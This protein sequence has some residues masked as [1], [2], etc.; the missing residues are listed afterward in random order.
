VNNIDTAYPMKKITV[1]FTL[2]AFLGLGSGLQAAEQT[3]PDSA[4]SWISQKVAPVRLKI[5]LRTIK[6]PK[7]WR[8][9][10]AIKDIPRRR[11][12]PD[13][14]IPGPAVNPVANKVDRL[15]ST[16]NS[17][18][19]SGIT[20]NRALEL[21]FDGSGYTGVN[22]PDPTGDIGLN[23]YIQSINGSGGSIFTVYD[24][25][26][27]ALVSGPTAM[28]SL[29]SGACANGSGDPIVLFDEMADRWL[30][31]EFSGSGNNLCVYI[32]QTSDPVT[33]GWFAYTFVTPNF[34]DYPKYAVG[35]DAYYVGTNENSPAVYALDRDA[36]LAGD[37][38][39]MIRLTAPALN[40][41][42]FQMLTPAD[43]DG[44]AAVP[45]GTPGYFLRHRDDEVHN[46]SSNN[47]AE[48]YVELWQ[49]VAD[50]D[51]VNNASFTKVADF[52]VADFSS[53]L[54]GLF[55]FNCFPQA[56]TNTTL[57]PL[58]EVVMFSPQYRNFGTY[59]TIV[60]NFVTDVDGT[61][62]GGIRWFEL[63]RENNSWS[64]FQEGTYAPD[65]KNRWMGS[66][67]M[68]KDGNIALGYS[69]GSNQ[70]FPGIRYTG[71]V[72]GGASGS[73][74]EPEVTLVNGTSNNA[75]N[76]WGDYSHMTVD[77]VDECTF[78]YTN[79]YGK[80]NGQWG[81]SIARFKFDSCGGGGGNI[82]PTA[83]FTVD[84]T[85][86]QCLFDGSGSMDPDGAIVSYDWD[87]GDGNSSNSQIPT[88]LYAASGTYSVSL[89]VTDDQGA[90]NVSSQEVTVDDGTATS[91]GFTE[92]DVSLNRNE[93]ATFTIEVPA[94]ADSLEVE[95]SGGTGNVDLL[96]KL[97][98]APSL[99]DN[100]CL[101][102]GPGNDHSCIIDNPD[103][104]TW[105]ITVRSGTTSTGVEVSA[106]WFKTGV[107][108]LPPTSDFSFIA[109]DLEV[110]FSDASSD[111]DGSIA[112]WDWDFGDGN[113][114]TA[115]NPVHDY[116][117]AGSYDVT[118]TVVDD[119]GDSDSSTQT[120][121][122]SDSSGMG[123]FTETDIV[124]AAGQNQDYTIDVP[125]GST[126]LEVA[127]SGGTGSIA[128]AIKFGSPPT[129]FDN[130]CIQLP[131]GTVHSCT[132]VNPAE[133][134]WHIRLRGAEASSGIRLDAYWTQ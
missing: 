54:C 126:S 70:D 49:M 10:D 85:L 65:S 38:A 117:A 17:A 6:R 23:Y 62:H 20:N 101:D 39:A 66:I 83:S 42:G 120:V 94:A 91:G 119:D 80:Q 74:T 108:N 118:L 82:S 109:N 115:Q 4:K 16:Q 41:F 33:G 121:V 30:L 63:R 79:Q 98:S 53:D 130:D 88:H 58:R 107:S 114:S 81:T 105:F 24:K 37:S 47:P 128:L 26:T 28:D 19:T 111:A 86:L 15:M 27:G 18:S 56:G 67:A 77:P 55:S 104:G 25:N 40:G 52:A 125:A 57:D 93:L 73:M 99:N 133:G 72:A 131:P 34:P 21:E 89:T 116:A 68:D 110:S 46:S 95:T 7:A 3:P 12:K 113:T 29:G 106:Y 100:D 92:T 123:G 87:F 14:V 69:W 35:V 76:R 134:T 103:Q 11:F 8:A 102:R 31:S 48:D 64:L 1:I 5:D 112:A 127:T 22:P 78:W 59:E 84:C 43:H 97:G 36:M 129:R 71:R 90:T 96:I 51:N 50:F 132:I 60:G 75:S 61:D 9:G 32:S 122:V 13:Y 2:L 124:I 45:L 44:T